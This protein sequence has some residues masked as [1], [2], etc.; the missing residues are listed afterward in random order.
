[1]LDRGQMSCVGQVISDG[2]RHPNVNLAWHW[3]PQVF[4]LEFQQ[5]IC[6]TRSFGG[7]NTGT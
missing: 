6:C 1:M 3:R 5:H 7:R 4:S 2:E